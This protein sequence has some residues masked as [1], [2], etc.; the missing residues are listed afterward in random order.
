MA[1]VRGKLALPGAWPGLMMLG[2]IALITGVLAVL[3]GEQF[4][5]HAIFFYLASTITIGSKFGSLFALASA[6][7][8]TAIGGIVLYEPAFTLTIDN[9]DLIRQR[10]SL[11]GRGDGDE[12]CVLPLAR[13]RD[14][15]A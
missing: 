9:A 5:P 1:R 6:W 14:R 13:E 7:L 15:L 8:S 3:G 4:S 12:H 2:T 11:R 10:P